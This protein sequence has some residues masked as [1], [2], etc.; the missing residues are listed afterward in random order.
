MDFLSS[1]SQLSKWIELKKGVLGAMVYS[2][3]IRSTDNNLDLK[4]VS[5][6]CV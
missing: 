6:G 1:V 2:H 5:A 4:L 3:A